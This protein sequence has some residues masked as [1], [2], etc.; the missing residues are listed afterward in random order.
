MYTFNC[1]CYF[2]FKLK[3]YFCLS[4]KTLEIMTN[5]NINTIKSIRK[6]KVFHSVN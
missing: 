5:L 1:R 4:L 2:L 6:T 3:T